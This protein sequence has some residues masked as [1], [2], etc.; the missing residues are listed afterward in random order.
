MTKIIA[1]AN[2]KGGVAKTSSTIANASLISQNKSCLVIDL[3]PQGNLTDGLGVREI[4]DDQLTAYN[5]LDL[6]Q[7]PNAI[8]LSTP[9][10]IDLIPT[11][12]GLAQKESELVALPDSHY[13]LKEQLSKL[14][15]YDYILIDCPPS[16]GR[17]TYSALTAA[18][19]VLIPVQCQYFS[20]KGYKQLLSTIQAVQ[21]R[22]NPQLRILGV[23]PT[24]SDN[25][26]ISKGAL[27]SLT[28]VEGVNV[29][30]SVPRSIKFTESQLAG[31][32][33]DRYIQENHSTKERDDL[34]EKLIE[35]YQSVVDHLLSLEV[36]HA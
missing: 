18:D 20:A 22:S 32:P 21:A 31:V 2:Q 25:T 1:I 15:Q 12:I 36:T 8:I 6:R 19:L 34:T 17:L 9:W 5:L 13:I 35:P 28:K 4:S 33:I 3:D 10:G 11:D 16:L 30:H 27:V 29:F 7:D 14:N 23:L 24:M 26:N